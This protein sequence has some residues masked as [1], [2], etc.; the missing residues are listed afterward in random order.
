[1]QPSRKSMFWVLSFIV[2]QEISNKY[3]K[4]DVAC[5]QCASTRSA[6]VNCESYLVLAV[7]PSSVQFS[8]PPSPLLHPCFIQLVAVSQFLP[9]HFPA[10]EIRW[11]S[12][13]CET[14]DGCQFELRVNFDESRK[15]VKH[16]NKLCQIMKYTNRGCSV[17]KGRKLPASL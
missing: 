11:M 2:P 14:R 1:M 8:F 5:T 7:S 17:L 9:S 12:F 10:A 6:T 15:L 16:S 13:R 4:C 3:P